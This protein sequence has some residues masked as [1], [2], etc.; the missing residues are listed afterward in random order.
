[1]NNDNARI[2]WNFTIGVSTS[3]LNKKDEDNKEELFKKAMVELTNKITIFSGGL[4]YNY[5]HGT[6]LNGKSIINSPIE[7][8][9]SCGISVIVFPKE[10]ETLYELVKKYTGEINNKYKL[11]LSHIQASKINSSGH[12]FMV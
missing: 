7:H 6:W 11:G 12:H 1:M 3:S 10:S 2:T 9:I 4:T 5:C 8:D